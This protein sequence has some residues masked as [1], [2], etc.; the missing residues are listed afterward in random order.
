MAGYPANRNRIS[1]TSLIVVEDSLVLFYIMVI[2][3]VQF[4][5]AIQ[6]SVVMTGLARC[7]ISRKTYM[8]FTRMGT[9]LKR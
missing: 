1:G 3:A 4:C 7:K 8:A 9:E 5:S 6:F 2:A